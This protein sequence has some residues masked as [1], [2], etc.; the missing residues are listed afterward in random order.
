MY[1][2]QPNRCEK[3]FNLST[4]P[5]S[6]LWATKY[7]HLG[8]FF[9]MLH[10]APSVPPI[11]EGDP[12]SKSSKL[13]GFRGL[14]RWQVITDNLCVRSSLALG[15]GAGGYRREAASRRVDRAV[16]SSAADYQL[17]WHDF[18]DVQS[19]P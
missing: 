15:E 4:R 6:W 1:K 18:C 10:L 12:N 3:D 5:F 16:K 9:K 17:D 2:Q 7:T 11:L 13:G 19:I 14:Y 8:C